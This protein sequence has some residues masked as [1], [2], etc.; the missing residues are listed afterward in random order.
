MNES[1]MRKRFVGSAEN[2]DALATFFT[3]IGFY[4][5]HEPIIADLG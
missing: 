1:E 2:A 5:F 3:A 4:A